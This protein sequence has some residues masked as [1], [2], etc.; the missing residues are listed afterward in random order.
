MVKPSLLRMATPRVAFVVLLSTQI[1][2]ALPT[3]VSTQ[4]QDKEASTGWSTEAILALVGIVVALLCCAIGLTW[5]SCRRALTLRRIRRAAGQTDPF[6]VCEALTEECSS[7]SP[8]PAR[9]TS[10]R[11]LKLPGA[12]PIRLRAMA[13]AIVWRSLSPPPLLRVRRPSRLWCG[14]RRDNMIGAGKL[15]GFRVERARVLSMS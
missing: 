3:G 7:A 15:V 1:A 4:E 12:R 11:T 13:T 9:R 10:S 8:S 5:P 2:H 6:Q 14:T